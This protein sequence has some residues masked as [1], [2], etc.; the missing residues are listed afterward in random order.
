[1]SDPGGGPDVGGGMAMPRVTS[2]V[3]PGQV[4]GCGHVSLTRH[5]KI[6]F[7]HENNFPKIKGNFLFVIAKVFN[8]NFEGSI[9]R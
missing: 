1:M 9:S 2:P 7:F 6:F 5:F 3:R 4:R 8:S